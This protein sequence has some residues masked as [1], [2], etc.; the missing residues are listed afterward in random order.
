MKKLALYMT[1]LCAA[2][3][4]LAC[5]PAP[6]FAAA[7][8]NVCGTAENMREAGFWIQR[9]PGADE[10]IM[11]SA[12]IAAFSAMIRQTP[13]THCTDILGYP[14][15]ISEEQLRAELAS[16]SIIPKSKRYDGSTSVSP[17]FWAEVEKNA[18]ADSVRGIYIV[19]FAV[20]CCNTVLKTLPTDTP[21]YSEPNSFLFDMNAA[22]GIKTWAPL[23]VLHTSADGRWI[24]VVSPAVSGW[25]PADRAAFADKKT[26]QE[27]ASR[28]FYVVTG[29]RITTNIETAAPNAPRRELIMGTR[30]PM[31]DAQKET[32]GI[33][34][35][36]GRAVLLPERAPDG[37]LAVK[38]ALLPLNADVSE[39]FIP[40][41][42][43][44]VIKQAFKMLGERY[45][46][47]DTFGAR[48]CSSFIR[49]IYLTFGIE[50]PRNSNAQV[51][52]PSVHFDTSKLDA[53]AKEKILAS[54]PAGTL[55]Q[56]PGHIMLYLGSVNGKPYIIHAVYALGPSGKG[57]AEGRTLLNCVSVTDMNMTRKDGTRVIDNIKN[58]NIVKN[59]R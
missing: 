54:A 18:A 37:T 28:D 57:G 49:D 27:L 1:A 2:A 45:G 30:L 33:S 29:N 48:D 46:W 53:A 19:R 21:L 44:N 42:Q 32:G 7:A 20:A 4:V 11:T 25:M 31:A 24:F 47:A 22:R 14:D 12:D 23:A 8:P 51:R 58:I 26:L 17:A 35:L 43:A 39:G 13:K 10:T 55:V 41:T 59:E 38:E 56:M 34:T 15:M 9:T 52:I 36:F 16:G 6:S 3:V 5:A 50:L 40:Y